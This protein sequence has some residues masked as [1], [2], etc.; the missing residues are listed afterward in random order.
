MYP[1]SK[2]VSIKLKVVEVPEQITYNRY[3]GVAGRDHYLLVSD[4]FT[5][6]SLIKTF[7]FLFCDPSFTINQKTR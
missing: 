1:N 4:N 6:Q 7:Y 2:V 5:L 3:L